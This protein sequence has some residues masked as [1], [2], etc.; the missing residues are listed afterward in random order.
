[1][2]QYSR[3]LVMT[4]AFVQSLADNRMPTFR[5]QHKSCH[6]IVLWDSAAMAV[7]TRKLMLLCHNQG[8]DF[9]SGVRQRQSG[10]EA[11]QYYSRCRREPGVFNSH[12]HSPDISQLFCTS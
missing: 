9:R 1:M 8:H 6:T 2:A 11:N 5:N 12:E 7:A 4:G 3:A 10:S